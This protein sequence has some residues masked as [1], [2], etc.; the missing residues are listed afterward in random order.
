M[1]GSDLRGE[2][3]DIGYELFRDR[4]TFKATFLAADVFADES[5]LTRLAGTLDVIYAGSFFHLFD[6]ARQFA[7]AL[8]CVQLL[9]P[10]AGSLLVGRQ[11]GNERAGEYVVRG[12]GF[13]YSRF[14]HDADSWREL[15]ERVGAETGTR[16]DVDARMDEWG[17]W[18]EHAVAGWTSGV[19]EGGESED[20]G[21]RKLSF[22]VRR[23]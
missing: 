1:Y 13:E 22:A 16:W 20:G 7:A 11:V 6:G 12:R 18:K 14:R 2:Y 8:R 10:R 19:T 4:E 17:S 9:A 3:F 15:W 23:L 5:P 21:A